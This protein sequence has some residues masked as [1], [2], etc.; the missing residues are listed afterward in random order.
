MARWVEE[1]ALLAVPRAPWLR[2]LVA[3]QQVP[4][5]AGAPWAGFAAPIL[6]LQQLGW[7]DWYCY[8]KRYHPDLTEQL[9]QQ[10][11]ELVS[12]RHSELGQVLGPPA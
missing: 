7:E 11:H 10:L 4:S 12:G 2:I 9:A 8:G 6:Q 1:S 3:G 5:P